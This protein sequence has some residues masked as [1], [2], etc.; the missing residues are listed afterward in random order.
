MNYFQKFIIFFCLFVCFGVSLHLLFLTFS[1]PSP[2]GASLHM[3]TCTGQ[4]IN[5]CGKHSIKM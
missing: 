3:E 2:F 1:L 5:N 4:H